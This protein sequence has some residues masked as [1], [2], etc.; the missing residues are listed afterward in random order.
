MKTKKNLSQFAPHSGLRARLALLFAALTM[1]AAPLSA[2]Q[3]YPSPEAAAN[4]FTDAIASNDDVALGTVLGKNWKRFIPTGEV[5][6]DDIYAFLSAWAKSHQVVEQ[7]PDQAV[8]EVG[9]GWTLPIPIVKHGGGWQFDLGAGADEMRTRRI[10]RNEL[11]AMQAVLA[12]YDAQKDYASTDRSGTGVLQYAQQFRSSA[13]KHDGL[14][15]PADDNEAESPLGPSFAL[16][17]PGEG[18]HGYHYRILRS[19]GPDA[20]GGAYD[21]VIKGRMTAGFAL[22]AWPIR[23]GDTGVTSFMISHDGQLYEKDLGPKSAAIAKAMKRFNPDASWQKVPLPA[24][25]QS[26]SRTDSGG[27]S[28]MR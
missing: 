21:Y 13:G 12:Y 19:Q 26:A 16:L 11:N 15:W 2:Q 22:V 25:P 1:A 10:G 4:A 18:Y 7:G 3:V 9:E 28:A 20:P 24:P 17:K 5:N 27:E 6:R 8:L 14:Y 23:Y